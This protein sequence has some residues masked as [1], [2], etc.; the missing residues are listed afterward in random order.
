VTG[1]VWE[2]DRLVTVAGDG[3]ARVATGAIYWGRGLF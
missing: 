3:L 2:G 1:V